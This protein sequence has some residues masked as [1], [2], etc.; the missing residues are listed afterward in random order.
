LLFPEI[1]MKLL[2]KR[3]IMAYYYYGASTPH[4]GRSC[5]HPSPQSGE[6]KKTEQQA[7]FSTDLTPGFSRG[8]SENDFKGKEPI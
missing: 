7:P 8:E 5:G 2:A 1:K 4:P 3:G 6:E